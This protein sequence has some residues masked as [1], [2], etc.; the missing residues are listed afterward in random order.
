MKKTLII[1]FM[2]FSAVAFTQVVEINKKV[3]LESNFHNC[4]SE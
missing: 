4:F 1:V 2:L 3:L